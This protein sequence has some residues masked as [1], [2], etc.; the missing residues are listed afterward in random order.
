[1][2]RNERGYPQRPAERQ[3]ECPMSDTAALFGMPLGYAYVPI[4]RWQMMYAPEEALAK[5]TLFEELYKP[6]GVYGNE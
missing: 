5:G 2:E 4:Q 6:L 1:M 3:D